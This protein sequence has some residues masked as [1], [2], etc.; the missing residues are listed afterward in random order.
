MTNG[1]LAI[2]LLS[3]WIQVPEPERP[4]RPPDG[5]WVIGI[6]VMSEG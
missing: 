3:L 2:L 4:P 1:L 6:D 5:G